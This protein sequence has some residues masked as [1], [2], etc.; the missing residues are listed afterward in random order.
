MKNR[1][2]ASL[3]LL[4]LGCALA[5]A[6]TIVY[7]VGSGNIIETG[8][9]DKSRFESDPRYGIAEVADDAV[10]L[11]L[12]KSFFNQTTGEIEPKTRAETDAIDA[13]AVYDQILALEK[14]KTTLLLTRD[15]LTDRAVISLIEDKIVLIDTELQRL[16][17]GLS[18]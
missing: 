5:F 17:S 10:P 15:R 3:V 11:E 7:E 18:P 13:Q 9:G 8:R 2:A 1:I 14:E 6:A 12:G 16:L 4:F